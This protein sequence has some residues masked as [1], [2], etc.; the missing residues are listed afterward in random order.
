MERSG[1]N[2]WDPGYAED[3]AMRVELLEAVSAHQ[4]GRRW[5]PDLWVFDHS[6]TQEDHGTA[7][8]VFRW[9]DLYQA[10]PIKAVLSLGYQKKT[11]K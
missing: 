10:L 9:T 11:I 8:V 6:T 2:T 1:R 4:I 7:A 3:R 5:L